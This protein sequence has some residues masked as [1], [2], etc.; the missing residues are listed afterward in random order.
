MGLK[1]EPF[2]TAVLVQFYAIVSIRVVADDA[3]IY[4]L[5]TV[6]FHRKVSLQLRRIEKEADLGNKIRPGNRSQTIAR[7]I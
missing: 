5:G 3:S 6:N 1:M 4:G 2:S 7:C